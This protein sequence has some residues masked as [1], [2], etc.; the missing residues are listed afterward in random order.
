M[1]QIKHVTFISGQKEALQLTYFRRMPVLL[2]SSQSYSSYM[3]NRK[4]LK[5]SLEKT[6]SPALSYLRIK[7]NVFP[8]YMWVCFC[9]FV[10]F[11]FVFPMEIHVFIQAGIP[12]L[13]RQQLKLRRTS[14]LHIHTLHVHPVFFG[15]TVQI[16]LGF[17]YNDVIRCPF[18]PT[19]TCR[20]LNIDLLCL[21]PILE[22]CR[23]Q[24]QLLVVSTL[25]F[26]N[27]HFQFFLRLK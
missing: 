5:L 10:L 20:D 25:S 7:K 14:Q 13:L 2:H 21:L 16:L 17:S 11:C 8:K 12:F 18:C 23:K 27:C 3:I 1:F 6:M 4:I 26:H 24:L 19:C 22:Q 9:F 15:I